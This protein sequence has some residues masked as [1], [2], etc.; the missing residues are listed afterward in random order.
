MSP[1][2]AVCCWIATWCGYCGGA[3]F[4][5]TSR[6]E[7]RR[8]TASSDAREFGQVLA[9][10]GVS[11]AE[12]PPPASIDSAPLDLATVRTAQAIWFRLAQ[13]DPQSLSDWTLAPEEFL[14]AWA[15]N[16]LRPGT[17]VRIEGKV[18]SCAPLE[19]LPS[20]AA[21]VDEPSAFRCRLETA[22]GKV[23]VLARQTPRAWRRAERSAGWA[24]PVALSG[25]VLSV[26]SEAGDLS[27]DL[28]RLAA[29]AGRFAWFPKQGVSP[30][31]AWLVERG[32]DAALWDD[33]RH[34]QPFA[35]PGES[36]E[37]DLFYQCLTI[38]SGESVSGTANRAREALVSQAVAFQEQRRRA[39][40]RLDELAEHPPTSDAQRS[41][42]RAEQD[43]ARRRRAIAD[44]ALESIA[45]GTSSVVPLFLQPQEHTGDWILLEGTARRA[46]R[47]VVDPAQGERAVVAL[48]AS[49]RNES[50]APRWV[51]P[52]DYYE[53]EFF[54]AD[55]QNLPVVCCAADLPAGFPT[56]DAIR[57]PIRVAGVF[58]KSWLYRR[59]ASIPGGGPEERPERLAVPLV[60]AKSPQWLRRDPPPSGP[61]GLIGGVGFLVLLAG[62]WAVMASLARGDRQARNRL[63][64]FG[65]RV[66]DT[67]GRVR[68]DRATG[69]LSQRIATPHRD[70]VVKNP[71]PW[72]TPRF[73]HGMRFSTWVGHLVRCRLA[74]SPSR[75][76]A[77]LSITGI[78]GLNSALAAVERVCYGRRIQRTRL[79]HAP[80]FIL[81][82]W[83]SGTT[84]LHELL[85][86]DP[87]HTYP[88]TYQCFAPHHFVLTDR[89][90]TPWTEFL[91]P[92]RRP[93]DNMAAGWQR[94]QEDEFAL[95]NLGVPTPY[96]SMMFPNRG[97]VYPEY[98]SLEDLSDHQ[99]ARWQAQLQQFLQ[100]IAVRD[101]R[102]IVVKSP[103]H[104]ARVR[105]LLEM[106]PDAKFVHIA[107]EPHTL[108]A[109]TVSLWRSLNEVQGMQVPRDDSWL[110]P[111]VIESFQR[112]YAAYL[113]DRELLT[114]NQLVEVTYE[115][116][117]VD[118][119]AGVRQIYAE[120]E[121]GDFEAAEAPL[122]AYLAAVSNYRPNRH[123]L[124]PEMADE[125]REQWDAYYRA[126]GF[127]A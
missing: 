121:L 46:V 18:V 125:L 99:R 29:V 105:W 86:R 43:S 94:P 119:K 85:I 93:M 38:L 36:Q 97:A 68:R 11:F 63:L 8:P 101:N 5:E 117:I 108:Y 118:P 112:M 51:A 55:A 15:A 79:A 104:T 31:V 76:P 30:G 22:G 116:L 41:A 100:R 13:F 111:Y 49:T 95:G 96:L 73:W 124:D 4:A 27:A 74:V 106:F 57:E 45:A 26:A 102:R 54:P 70:R 64:Q 103:P 126:F 84:F 39:A 56:G 20:V 52:A 35:K 7:E 19:V 107:R 115:D 110:R 50:S 123:E 98:L 120:L 114:Q 78:S 81:G 90:F 62:I 16:R 37:A 10:A 92:S 12:V 87:R 48:N 42:W 77:A 23:T 9:E 34:R 109:S 88:T 89:W 17:L 113:R 2:I 47:I 127:G 14:R 44:Q 80:L 69:Q 91:L 82:H 6:A 53:I 61:W 122:D 21:Q 83:R 67:V 3:F 58:F 60:I 65:A 28:P 32:L 59:R 75:L 40:R 71:L 66:T 1:R 24:E 33:V 72:Y 25:V